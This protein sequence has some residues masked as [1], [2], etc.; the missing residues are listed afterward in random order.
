MGQADLSL[1]AIAVCPQVGL[2]VIEAPPKPFKENIA[3][4]ALSPLPAD[5]DPLPL[6]PGHKIRGSELTALAGVEDCWPTAISD[7][8]LN[9]IQAERR[10][11]ADGELPA[12]H[13]PGMEI[14]DRHQVEEAFLQR[15]VGD[16]GRPDLINGYALLDVHQAG[17]PL[18]GSPGTVVRG[19]CRSPINLHAPHEVPVS[20]TADRDL[21]LGHI[22]HHPAAA[23]A[24]ILQLE[25][26]DLG[27]DPHR[28]F[29]HRRRPVVER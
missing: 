27:H 12:E 2:L 15:D 11:K 6:E 1:P 19:S 9:G 3:G 8:N 24:G 4:A 13:I 20:V 26:V 29:A 23:A 28:R 17:K 10:V 25:G 22:D 5:L 7:C 14:H 16:A 18:V 21:F